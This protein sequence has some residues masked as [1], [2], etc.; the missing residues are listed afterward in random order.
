[1]EIIMKTYTLTDKQLINLI[2]LARVDGF[3]NT[4]EG[5]NAEYPFNFDLKD[6]H[7]YHK[8]TTA[9]LKKYIYKAKQ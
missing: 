5:Y 8:P 3:S 9:E 1:M 7:E 6:I 2:Q 4:S